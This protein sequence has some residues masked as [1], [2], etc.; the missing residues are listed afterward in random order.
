MKKLV[1]SLCAVVALFAIA[2]VLVA[3][4]PKDAKAAKEKLAKAG[5]TATIVYEKTGDDAKE[6]AI[7]NVTAV[8]GDSLGSVI[9]SAID[10][11]ALT[12]TL[13]ASSKEAKEAYEKTKDSDGKT[14]AQLIGNWVVLGEEAAIKAFK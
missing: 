7:A 14:S 11:K 6:G 4:A 13:Y 5:Y 8:K 10:G 9:G 1:K 12:A 3:C 2:L